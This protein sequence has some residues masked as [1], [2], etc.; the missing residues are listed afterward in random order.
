MNH[1]TT[2]TKRT[3]YPAPDLPKRSASQR[4]TSECSGS[5]VISPDRIWRPVEP[6]KSLWASGPEHDTNAL[7]R[8]FAEARDKGRHAIEDVADEYIDGYQLDVMV[9]ALTKR[10]RDFFSS[11]EELYE[12]ENRLI[13]LTRQ[14]EKDSPYENHTVHSG[15][16]GWM[17][18][19]SKAYIQ[20]R[21]DHQEHDPPTVRIYMNPNFNAMLDVYS[22]VF[23]RSEERGLRFQAKVFDP[24]LRSATEGGAWD[25]DK[26]TGFMKNYANMKTRRRG[27]SIVFYG[28][29]GSEDALLGVATEVYREHG[30][31][32]LDR[33]VP[34]VPLRLAD[35]LAV[36]EEPLGLSGAESLSGHREAVL[37]KCLTV[38]RE[39]DP[40]WATRPKAERC[41]LF[42]QR[43]RSV[44]V[45]NHINP[46]N[47]AFNA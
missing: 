8:T 7:P 15:Q 10:D 29:E 21:V 5:M 23:L 35:G 11:W 13:K 30:A 43:F 12:Y 19:S 1:K 28:Y 4:E 40:L 41:R 32:F 37:A 39:N 14:L 25:T 6:V 18:H 9:A 20:G 42:C 16:I 2:E 45:L 38:L 47:I 22:E 17:Q 24:N 3:W 44:A 26:L 33:D 27:D 34:V 31:A 36:G 46:N